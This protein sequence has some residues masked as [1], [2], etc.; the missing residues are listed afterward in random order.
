MFRLTFREKKLTQIQYIYMANRY[1]VIMRCIDFPRK[2]LWDDLLVHSI[3]IHMDYRSRGYSKL[4][5][6]ILQV[7]LNFCIRTENVVM[8]TRHGN[9]S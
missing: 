4:F 2:A 3:T 8:V 5:T 6:N 9:I 1:G 7:I